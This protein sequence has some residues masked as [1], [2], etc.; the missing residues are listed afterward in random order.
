MA[1]Q[2]VLVSATVTNNPRKL[3]PLHLSPK[4]VHIQLSQSDQVKVCFFSYKGKNFV[5]LCSPQLTHVHN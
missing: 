3:Q 5:V 1:V 4:C 2:K